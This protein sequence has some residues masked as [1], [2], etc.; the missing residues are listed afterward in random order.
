[1][2][3]HIFIKKVN[4]SNLANHQYWGDFEKLFEVPFNDDQFLKLV[5]FFQV[6]SDYRTYVQEH[7]TQ[8]DGISFHFY[9]TPTDP[10]VG[11]YIF[12]LADKNDLNSIL[13]NN[14]FSDSYFEKRDALFSELGWV[15]GEERAIE[16][17]SSFDDT[18]ITWSN[19]PKTF[20]EVETMYNNAVPVNIYLGE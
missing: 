14:T 9:T 8:S 10:L 3:L 7:L 11:Y 12:G 20:N 17:E 6:G 16:I 18:T 2:K 13:R 1:M 4:L 5:E 15:Q 19:I